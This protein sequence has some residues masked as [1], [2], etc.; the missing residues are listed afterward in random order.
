MDIND[1]HK[2]P[3]FSLMHMRG[4]SKKEYN[5]VVISKRIIYHF[6]KISEAQSHLDKCVSEL[7]NISQNDN[8]RKN[9][10]EDNEVLGV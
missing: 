9:E 3:G 10:D 7:I 4:E 2:I 5:Q 8:K 1:L 6:Y